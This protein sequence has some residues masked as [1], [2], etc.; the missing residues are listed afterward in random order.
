[1]ILVLCSSYNQYNLVGRDFY[2]C[3]VMRPKKNQQTKVGYFEMHASQ[4]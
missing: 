2:F 3:V 1:M 4:K